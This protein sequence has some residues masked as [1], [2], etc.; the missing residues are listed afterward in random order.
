MLD[1][2]TLGK[3]P[4]SF[5]RPCRMRTTRSRSWLPP[6]LTS[7]VS[8]ACAAILIPASVSAVPAPAAAGN[9]E[10]FAGT[11]LT[12]DTW[13]ENVD[14]GIWWVFAHGTYVFSRL[15]P[16][17]QASGAFFVRRTVM[18]A[19]LMLSAEGCTR[20]QTILS[21][22]QRLCPDLARVRLISMRFATNTNH[23]LGRAGWLRLASRRQKPST[24][25]LDRS[26]AVCKVIY[27][28]PTRSEDTLPYT[29]TK[30]ENSSRHSGKTGPWKD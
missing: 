25:T 7:L 11:L 27:A 9:V 6:S 22:L 12:P 29:C 5:M 16:S 3:A 1:P 19:A 28:I 26:T 18:H 30:M 13:K 20:L 8:L 17:V 23:R 24:S 15:N 10:M 21:P 14:N 2:A 4:A